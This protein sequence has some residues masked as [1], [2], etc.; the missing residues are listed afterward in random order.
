[1]NLPLVTG[2]FA[3]ATPGGRPVRWAATGRLGGASRAPWSELNLADHVGDDP[4]SVARNREELTAALGLRALVYLNAEHG[5]QVHS[6][7][8]PQVLMPGDACITG[9]SSLG[10]VALGADCATV[11]IAGS[12]SIAVVHCGWRGLVAGVMPAALAELAQVDPGPFSA[13]VGPHICANCY[14]V[15]REVWEAVRGSAPMAAVSA[16]ARLQIDLR[17]GIVEQSR[18]WDVHWTVAGG[19]TFETEDLFSYRRDGV[20]GRHGLVIWRT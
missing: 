6:V 20:T 1:M 5:A 12:T 8:Q 10:L 17:S 14:P 7:K 18:P 19:C 9:E 4:V 3:S 15:G 13:V 11:G 2:E 16:D